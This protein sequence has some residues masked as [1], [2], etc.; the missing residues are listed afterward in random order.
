LRNACI[1]VG[2]IASILA[3]AR[4][5]TPKKPNEAGPLTLAPTRSIDFKTD[6]GTWISLD[7]SP[8]G[9]TIAFE[10]LGDLY[11]LPFQGGVAKPL[12]SGMAYD[13][14][15]RF[16][17]DGKRLVFISDRDGADNVW[18]ADAD[19][20]HAYALTKDRRTDWISPEWTP[21]G[22]FILVERGSDVFGGRELWMY[23][24]NGGAGIQVT[25]ASPA[26]KTPSERQSNVAGAVAS[27]DGKY[28]Y[29][30]RRTGLF[31]YNA[32]L[33]LWQIVRRDTSN[34]MEDVIT[35]EEGSAIRPRVSPDGRWLV[36]GT[37]EDVKT[38]LRA[39]DLKT[40]AEHWIRYGIDRDDQEGIAARD[41]LPGYAFTPDS[42]SIVFSYGGH[43]HTLDVVSGAATE[44][45]FWAEVKQPLGPLV[46]SVHRV[47]QGP[48]IARI[49]SDP[50]LSPD[51]QQVTFSSL[52]HVFVAPVAGG[53]P[54]RLTQSSDAEF[55]PSWSPDGKSISFVTWDALAGGAIW[56]MNA[57]GSGA[58]KRI[59]SVAAYYRQ[60]AW[61]PDG[62][63]IYAVRSSIEARRQRRLET[64]FNPDEVLVGDDLIRV[65]A[66]GGD[67]VTVAPARGASRPQF[68]KVSDRLFVDS[69]KGLISMR[70]DGSDVQEL[71]AFKGKDIQGKHDPVVAREV[72]ISPDQT[73]LLALINH[74]VWLFKLPQ[75][76]GP[77]V[78]VDLDKPSILGKR[79]TT[80]GADSLSWSSKGDEV[81]WTIGATLF[82]LP[83]A[84]VQAAITADITPPA[85][86]TS[87]TP[88]P[89]AAKQAAAL[90]PTELALHVEEPRL[91]PGGFVVLRGGRVITMKGDEVLEHADVVI[92]GDRI[93]AIGP[94]GKVT[95]PSGAKVL[96][97]TGKTIMPGIVDAHAHFTPLRRGLL[98]LQ[99]WPMEANLAYG[100]TA[101]RDPQT[102]TTDIFAY[103]DLADTGRVLG[104]RAFSTGPG[105]FSEN[106]LHSLDDARHVI[107]RYTRYYRTHLLKSY[108]V[109]N[110]QQRQWM[111]Q[112]SAE[113]GAMPT[114]E[115]GI[116]T[117]MDMS[118]VIDG[119][120]GNEHNLPQTPLYRDIVQLQA[121]SGTSYTPTLVVGYGGP[122]A[123]EYFVEH[124]DLFGDPKLRHFT[125][126]L[127][128]HMDAER[129][130][131]VRD[132]EYIFPQQATDAAK[133]L[134]AGGLVAL[135]GH[136]QM[137]GIQCHWEMWS[138]A[139]GG[140]TPLEV[141][142]VATINGAKAIGLDQDIG[143][144]ETGKLADLVVLDKNPLQDIHNTNT[145]RWVMRGGVVYDGATLNEVYPS[146]NVHP[147]SWWQK[148]DEARTASSK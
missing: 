130:Q 34:G 55:Q 147:T 71:V 105:I 118:Q 131:W 43:I 103:Q 28:L 86:A 89:D 70:A 107:E 94:K 110:R 46:H 96:D 4:A 19:G 75:V 101:T 116:D 45:P 111:V 78:E 47:E 109:G 125:P 133:I 138:F 49:A 40:G 30:S 104:P 112:A 72:A 64:M 66:Q 62:T 88:A 108:E 132:P 135:G 52:A 117:R 54:H 11:T 106:D 22:R 7:L 65:S 53:A 20:S 1:G 37:R 60:P 115:G 83:L 142:R 134:R 42:K 18:I 95:T 6:E 9:K 144:L 139:M 24:T 3:T 38:G 39:R 100:V 124:T 81:L 32:K 119:F 59:T 14:Q 114:T 136:G 126:P 16:A 50:V 127:I 84:R 92:T 10:L 25:K 2:V 67:A 143:S 82:R 145:I 69:G 140:M 68:T 31:G 76:G 90:Q 80:D 148:D 48:V 74:Q 91:V 129:A 17:P 99:S 8:D 41:L 13:S 44:I 98:E 57:D 33:P 123:T 97:V 15:P 128:L 85:P 79:L 120:T 137:Q 58:A 122:T 87:L 63:Q 146:I 29:Y 102:F 141:I 35:A 12:M 121:Q 51:G 36:Y 56:K 77:A 23:D 113:L 5:Q 21:D 61:S 26:P 93:V 27:P 73:M